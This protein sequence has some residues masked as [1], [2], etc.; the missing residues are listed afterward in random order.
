MVPVVENPR[1]DAG[2]ARNADS[3]PWAGV[4]SPGGGNGNSSILS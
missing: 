2:D 3:I 4:R 1:A